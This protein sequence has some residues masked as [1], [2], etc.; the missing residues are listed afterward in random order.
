LSTI[1]SN[2]PE[3]NAKNHVTLTKNFSENLV[4]LPTRTSFKNISQSLGF[5]QNLFP[6]KGS[7][8][9]AQQK[10]KTVKEKQKKQGGEK[11]KGNRRG[12]SKTFLKKT[13]SKFLTWPQEQKPA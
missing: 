4:P 12:G 6:P 2:R 7:L 9:N 10:K 5:L 8:V 11:V 1:Q 13:I 3:K